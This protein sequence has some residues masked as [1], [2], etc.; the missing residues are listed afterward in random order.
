M[1][2]QTLL[3]LI[4]PRVKEINVRGRKF[5]RKTSG[6]G[7][8]R[9][10]LTSDEEGKGYVGAGQFSTVKKDR[11][12]HFVQKT[13]RDADMARNDGYWYYIKKVIDNNL[14]ENPY[15]P[16]VYEFKKFY[17]GSNAHY[18]VK[19]ET[20]VQMEDL[21]KPELIAV[22]SR[23]IGDDPEYLGIIQPY[24]HENDIMD[25]IKQ[26][27]RRVWDGKKSDKMDTNFISAMKALKEI[28]KNTNYLYDLHKGNIMARRGPHG[29]HPVIVDPFSFWRSN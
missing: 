2:I 5:D 29:V 16:R 19:L 8:S 6:D 23:M 15:F 11:D 21:N 4:E 3:E 24:H 26:I 9:W 22:V 28:N 18:R 12:P 20:L 7:V 1:R 10:A 13:S 14:W 25:L 17:K 27:F